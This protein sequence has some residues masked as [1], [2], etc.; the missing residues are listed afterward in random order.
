MNKY[1]KK[2][3]DIFAHTWH[4]ETVILSLNCK[5]KIMNFFSGDAGDNL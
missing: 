2:L 3:V 5:S 1:A 4:I